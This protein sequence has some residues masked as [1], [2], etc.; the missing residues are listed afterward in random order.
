MLTWVGYRLGETIEA[1]SEP[2]QAECIQWVNEVCGELLTTLVSDGAEQGR[3]TG[4]ITTVDG[5]STYTE[6]DDA[7]TILD[8]LFAPCFWY[9]DNGDEYSAWVEETTKRT[10]IKY[11]ERGS[12]VDIDPSAEGKPTH[13]IISPQVGNIWFFPT[14]DDVYTIQVPYYPYPTILTLTTQTVP[15]YRIFDNVILESVVMRAQNRDEY[16]LTFELKW[17]S[18]IRS[19]AKKILYL[20]RNKKTR[21]TF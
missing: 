20:K 14:P 17:F 16:D 19:Q 2:S 3:N 1:A 10:P 13:Y 9:D 21:I 6:W 7:T 11:M 5:T 8:T 15:Y 4:A 18:Y 12:W